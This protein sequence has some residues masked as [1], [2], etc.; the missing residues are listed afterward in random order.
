VRALEEA[1]TAL[2]CH[3]DSLGTAK[4]VLD[5]YIEAS[6]TALRRYKVPLREAVEVGSTRLEHEMKAL[7]HFDEALEAAKKTIKR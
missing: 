7:E 5:Q 3:R 6:R 1:E 2:E 4:H